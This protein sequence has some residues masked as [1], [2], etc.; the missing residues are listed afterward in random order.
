[1]IFEFCEVVTDWNGMISI[2]LR[3][4]WEK[5]ISSARFVGR[6]SVMRDLWERKS[7]LH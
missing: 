1:L 4:L 3:D 2:R 5:K 6:K 7:I